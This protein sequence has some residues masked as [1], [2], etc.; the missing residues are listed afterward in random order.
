MSDL[1]DF[2]IG[3]LVGVGTGILSGMFG[4]GGAVVSTPAIRALGAT[5]LEAVGSTIPSVLPSALSGTLRYA[6][7]GLVRWR[8]FAWTAGF[9]V[10]AAVGGALLT[11]RIPGDGRLLMLA[12][13]A[14]LAFTAIRLARPPRA[15][16]LV[17]AEDRPA[18]PAPPLSERPGPAF[19]ATAGVAA[20]A[21]SGLLGIGGGVLLVPLYTTWMRLPLKAAIATSLAC[22]GALS[23]PSLVTHAY[24]GH[25]DWQYALPLTIGVVPGA[26]LGAH[27]AIRATERTLRIAVASV[28]GGIAVIYFAGELRSL[29]G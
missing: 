14:L 26:Q 22:V 1:G 21:L 24:L 8:V 18:T 15:P 5:P 17:A 10:L 28:L 2:L 7:E 25:V 11:E 20:G 12:T 9:G 16:A 6:R 23:V 27:L 4:V 3:I 29:L 19:C 13:A